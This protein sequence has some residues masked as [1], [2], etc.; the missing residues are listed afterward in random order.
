MTLAA[1]KRGDVLIHLI[2]PLGTRSNLIAKRPRDYSR[3]GFNDWPFMSVHMWGEAPEGKWILEVQNEGRSIVQL[4]HWG[5]VLHGTPE[6]PNPTLMAVG[7]GSKQQASSP[8]EEE[9]EQQPEAKPSLPLPSG[10]VP[11]GYLSG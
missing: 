2:S 4:K 3:A 5:L 11:V 1:S 9:K 8:S 7:G 6:Q 10:G